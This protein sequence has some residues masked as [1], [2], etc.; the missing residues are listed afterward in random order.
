[1]KRYYCIF[2]RKN[3][4]FVW[5]LKPAKKEILAYF[6]SRRDCVNYYLSLKKEGILWFQKSESDVA[7][8]LIPRFEGTL[9]TVKINSSLI[10]AIYFHQSTKILNEEETL[11]QLYQTWKIDS[12][13]GEDLVTR[14]GGNRIGELLNSYLKFEEFDKFKTAERERIEKNRQATLELELVDEKITNVVEYNEENIL[15]D[16]NSKAQENKQK[17][18]DDNEKIGK[19]TLEDKDNEF[20]KSDKLGETKEDFSNKTSKKSVKQKKNIDTSEEILAQK[21]NEQ[22]YIDKLILENLE[23]EKSLEKAKFLNSNSEI[24]GNNRLNG[25]GS[26]LDFEFEPK[27]AKNSFGFNNQSFFNRNLEPSYYSSIGSS[28]RT[29][30]MSNNGFHSTL[31]NFRVKNSFSGAKNLYKN[32]VLDYNR[33]RDNSTFGARRFGQRV[34]NGDLYM[35]QKDMMWTTNGVDAV[36]RTTSGSY[37]QHPNGTIEFTAVPGQTLNTAVNPLGNETMIIAA[38]QYPTNS[39]YN[40]QQNPYDMTM[41][42][43]SALYQSTPS[44]VTEVTRTEYY[45]PVSEFP[46]QTYKVANSNYDYFGQEQAALGNSLP[47]QLPT[48]QYNFQDSTP[49]FAEN[50]QLQNAKRPIVESAASTQVVESYDTLEADIKSIKAGIEKLK[51]DFR[52]TTTLNFSNEKEE[53]SKPISPPPVATPEPI[54]ELVPEPTLEPVKQKP[55]QQQYKPVAKEEKNVVMPNNNVAATNQSINYN[56]AQN[57]RVQQNNYNNQNQYPQRQR[58]NVSRVQ[59]RP[60]QRPNSIPRKKKKKDPLS[61]ILVVVAIL[62]LVGTAVFLGLYFGTDLMGA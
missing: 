48:N 40:L 11:S 25:W 21:R 45:S 41:Q 53:V 43:N 33:K 23:L 1:M 34:Q 61:I 22:A 39:M 52:E 2:D 51:E 58:P 15:S 31:N 32:N 49:Y 28:I 5:K 26:N 35:Q 4:P 60:Q 9:R 14:S 20:I 59:Q 47:P 42:Q 8:G 7:K 57:R 24:L 55:A 17:D 27:F 44:V 29:E 10:H 38:P 30:N 13:T 62:I 50:N 3:H 6:K 18:V 46:Q 37:I 16:S 12:D 54:Q 56:Q 19:S 36:G